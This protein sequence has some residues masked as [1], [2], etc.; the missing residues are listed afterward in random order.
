MGSID[1]TTPLEYNMMVPRFENINEELQ[2]MDTTFCKIDEDI[3]EQ[4]EWACKTTNCGNIKAL[5]RDMLMEPKVTREKLADQ[6]LS[7]L[8]ILKAAR[9]LLCQADKTIANVHV[10]CNA[11][12]TKIIE[13]QNDMLQIK[14]EQI[15]QV[16]STVQNE[17]KS[18]CDIAKKFCKKTAVSPEKLKTIVKIVA[19]EEL[20]KQEQECCCV[21]YKRG[22]LRRSGSYR[23]GS[24]RVQWRETSC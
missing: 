19:E 5:T 11:H 16:L 21:L 3:T 14:N 24:A 18:Y 8:S 20:R 13:L 6:L 17:T 23:I 22:D 7:V 12:K 15:N 1:V 10:E 2:Y 4:F 9:S